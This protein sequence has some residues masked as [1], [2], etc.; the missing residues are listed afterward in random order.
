MKVGVW[1]V[2]SMRCS[3][4][5]SSRVRQLRWVGKPEREHS[6]KKLIVLFA[7]L[8]SLAAA[9]EIWGSLNLTSLHGKTDKS[10][11]QSN[12][13][14]GGEYHIDGDLLYMAGAY[15]NSHRRTS[16][17]ILAGWTPLELGPMKIGLA[18]GLVNAYPK[19]NHGRITGAAALLVRM[20]GERFGANMFVIPPALK[21]SP[22][23]VGF[24]VKIRF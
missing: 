15:R 2:E 1:S 22:V 20:E 6:V 3:A 21:D 17:Y 16:G 14:L 7:L 9:A 13:G 12:F 11:N 24:Q 10:M 18:G 4:V 5:T 23:T 8:P 19:R